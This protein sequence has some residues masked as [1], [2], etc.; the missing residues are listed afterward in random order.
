MSDALAAN[1]VGTFGK[2][3]ATY[4]RLMLKKVSRY[5]SSE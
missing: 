2:V 5:I 4:L 3:R 1:D